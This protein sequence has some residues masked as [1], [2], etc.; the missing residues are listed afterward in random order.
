MV[1]PEDPYVCIGYFQ[2]A[3]KEVDLNYCRNNNI[4]VIRRETGGGTVYIDSGQLFVQWICQPGF[5]PPKVE[6]RFQL[7]N[8]ALIETYKFFGIQ[9]YHY[10]INDVHVEGRKIVGTGAATIGEAEVITG[11]FLYDFDPEIMTQ[12]LSLPNTAMRLVIGE[13]LKNYMTW[14]KREIGDPPSYS[15]IIKVY[16]KECEKILGARLMDGE[17]T[18]EEVR[19]IEQAEAK[20]KR[21][22]WLHKVKPSI[23]KKNR[24]VKIHAG[25]W[26][27]WIAFK[28]NDFTIEVFSQMRNNTLEMIHFH[29]P[30]TI[31]PKWKLNKLEEIL[32]ASPM[33]EDEIRERVDGFFTEID[34]SNTLMTASHWTE[35]VMHIKKEVQKMSGNA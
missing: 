21:E 8:K 29:L 33:E 13:S 35:A 17:F 31:N 3:T 32:I 1:I 5:L 26:V 4:P 24:L 12:V 34:R 30:P 23:L 27:G 15:E 18:G 10:P 7:F 2:D 9:A 14:I 28:V 20:L 11:N 22:D 19:A 25:V 16:R 6:H